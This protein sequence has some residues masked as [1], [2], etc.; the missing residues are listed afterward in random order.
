MRSASK[1]A[2]RPGPAS[3]AWPPAVAYGMPAKREL[4]VPLAIAVVAMLV[5]YHRGLVFPFALDDYTYLYRAAGI[6]PDPFSLRRLLSTRVFYKVGY[7]LFGVSSPVPWHIVAF[8]LHA[9]NAVWVYVLARRVGASRA[10]AQLACGLFAA[11]PVAFTVMYWTAGIQEIWSGFFLFP[12]IWLAMRED[13]WRWLAVPLYGM[14]V[15]CKEAVVVAPAVLP[16]LVGRRGVRLALVH[17]VLGA[18]LFLG[19]GLLARAFDS[20]PGSPYATSYAKP[21]FANLA[22]G[23][24][25]LLTPWRAYPDRIPEADPALVP[26]GAA[27]WVLIAGLCLSL[28]RRGGG[29][30]LLL[31]VAW[32]VALLLPALPLRG[33]FY[34]YYLYLPQVSILVAFAAGL[35]HLIGRIVRR[36]PGTAQLDLP[37]CAVALALGL[38]AIFGIRNARTHEHLTLSDP[39]IPHDSVVRYARVSG[40]LLQQIRDAKLEPQIHKIAVF[41]HKSGE[42]ALAPSSRQSVPGLVRKHTYPVKI[43]LREGRFIRLHFPQLQGGFVD[44]LTA[45]EETPDTAIFLTYGLA[46]LERIPDAAVAYSLLAYVDFIDK[47]FDDAQRHARRAVE[48]RPDDLG[49]QLV[50]AG[51]C[52]V[53]GRLQDAET[54]L[55]RIDPAA[56]SPALATFAQQIREVLSKV[57]AGG[58]ATQ[59]GQPGSK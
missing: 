33:H 51:L 22:T 35:L 23:L 39:N 49:A 16:L 6:D 55:N 18:G 3:G 21:L 40:M 44:S 29:R 38:C 42:G 46:S 48:L 17:L 47:R 34:A 45:A 10:A 4:L 26:W 53:N 12:A 1:Q 24:M 19:A 43:A 59:P 20:D 11:S 31:A 30:A 58:G 36:K 37:A 2:A 15:L 9:V 25:W 57:K 54:I 8:V 27:F 7:E 13:R 52:V 56:L 50:I 28:R 41:M 5:V 32:F 14:A